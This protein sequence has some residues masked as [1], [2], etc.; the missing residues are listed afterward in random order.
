[1]D[2]EDTGGAFAEPPS[3]YDLFG[4]P[5]PDEEAAHAGEEDVFGHLA[6]GSVVVRLP[7]LP[8]P[9]PCSLC[10]QA[11]CACSLGTIAF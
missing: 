2:G 3:N 7:P 11:P 5:G 8:G 10:H 1:M 4:P 6:A 9:R